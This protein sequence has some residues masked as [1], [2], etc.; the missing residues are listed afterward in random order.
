LSSKA[1]ALSFMVG[2]MIGEILFHF[3][4]PEQQRL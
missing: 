4:L 2:C 1:S 3:L